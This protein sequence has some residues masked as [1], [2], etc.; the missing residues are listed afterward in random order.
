MAWL[1]FGEALRRCF[2]QWE[3]EKVQGKKGG[4]T[5][6][7]TR[8][9]LAAENFNG[10]SVGKGSVKDAETDRLIPSAYNVLEQRF[11]TCGPPWVHEGF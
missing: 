11:S 10:A 9:A 4:L 5:G 6:E 7:K 1:S 8:H 2:S 3:R